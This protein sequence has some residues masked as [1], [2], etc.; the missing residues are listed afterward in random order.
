[1][2]GKNNPMYRVH[3]FGKKSPHYNKKHSD[4]SKKLISEKLKNWY[5]TNV[6]PMKNKKRPDLSLRN[7][8]NKGIKYTKEIN[9]KKGL[10]GE[11]NANWKGGIAR[12]PY[13]YEFTIIK[14]KIIN[15][16]KFCQIC[17]KLGK[18]VHH[19]DYN[20]KNDNKSNLIYLCS[21]CHTKTNFNK[22]YWIDLL[23]NFIAEK[24]TK[25]NE[26]WSYVNIPL[27][28]TYD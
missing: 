11:K 4:K 16:D 24:N 20:K 10:K 13:T 27:I 22:R 1:M 15:R 23:T 3:R 6:N 26:K 5:K 8:L 18:Y 21:S 12:L 19:I 28:T 25:Y 9:Q 14:P 7:K 17:G 2:R